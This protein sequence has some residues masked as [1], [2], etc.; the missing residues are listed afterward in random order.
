MFKGCDGLS[1]LVLPAD[2]VLSGD[3]GLPLDRIRVSADANEEQRAA[4]GRPW[5]SPGTIPS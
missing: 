3:L 2:A 5:A 1:Q 4:L